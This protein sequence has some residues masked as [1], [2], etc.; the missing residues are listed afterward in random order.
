[1][2]FLIVLI[3]DQLVKYFVVSTSLNIPIIKN[4]FNLMY[5]KNTGGMY[6]M[7]TNNNWL[8]VITSLA[9]LIIL[10]VYVVKSVD[11]NKPQ[12]TIWQFIIAGGV[13]NLIDRI[14]RGAVIDFIQLK[15][16]GVFNLAD[17]CIVIGVCLICFLELKEFFESG[18]NKKSSN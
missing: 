12:F 13:S 8:F 18:N 5:V 17:A 9:I 6:G 3:L 15:F 11:K 10:S 2:W 1:M 7:L 14:F 4:I 16:F